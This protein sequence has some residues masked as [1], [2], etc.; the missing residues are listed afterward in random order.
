MG[1]I[2]YNRHEFLYELTFWE[3][4]A[5]VNGYRRRNKSILESSR[6]FT[7][8]IMNALGAKIKDPEELLSFTWEREND[9]LPKLTQEDI[10]EMQSLMTNNQDIFKV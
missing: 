10:D 9:N 1:E 6:L 5:I 3:I 7:F 2:G 4:R 8:Y